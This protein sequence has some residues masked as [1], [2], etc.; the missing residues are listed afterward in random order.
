MV[1]IRP[2]VFRVESEFVIQLSNSGVR[3]IARSG[4]YFTAVTP[5]LRW[6]TAATRPP[7]LVRRVLLRSS[8]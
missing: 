2:A 3:R 5:D 8:L 4:D 7:Q 1:P 6:S